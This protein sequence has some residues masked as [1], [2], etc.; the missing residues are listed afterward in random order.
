[1]K[2]VFLCKIVGSTNCWVKIMILQDGIHI[3]LP[4]GNI[5]MTRSINVSF[6]R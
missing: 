6:Y 4:M 1:M 5:F 2:Y 3:G